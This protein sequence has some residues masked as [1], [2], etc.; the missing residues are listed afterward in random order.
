MQAKKSQYARHFESGSVTAP[1][2]ALSQTVTIGFAFDVPFA[3]NIACGYQLLFA[4]ADSFF[5]SVS[6]NSATVL[7]EFSSSAPIS[8]ITSFD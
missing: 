7:S 3:L 8:S 2:F 4:S 6:I 5:S 1:R